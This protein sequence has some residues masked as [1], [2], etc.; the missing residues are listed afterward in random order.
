MF[1]YVFKKKMG[2]E[3]KNLMRIK[4]Q[5]HFKKFTKTIET[6]NESEQKLRKYVRIRLEE[7]AGLR[8]STLNE[9]K[10]STTLKKLDSMIDE[11]FKLF[12]SVVKKK[13]KVNEVFGLN[14]LGIN[15]TTSEKV[16]AALKNLD[17]NDKN[18]V[19]KLL[20][21]AF[22]ILVNPQYIGAMDKA[23]MMT[24]TPEKYQLLQQYIANGGGTIRVG[25]SGKLTYISQK[26]K[27]TST[28]SEFGSG[29]TMGKTNMGGV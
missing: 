4:K 9:N 2:L 17:P 5:Q 6:M 12:E 14:K 29:G 26:T 28:K 25:K 20:T 13:G 24:S 8:K 19:D 16:A 21:T 27:D 23:R 3:K 15:L 22:N 18:A 10:K 7:K 11:Q 1:V